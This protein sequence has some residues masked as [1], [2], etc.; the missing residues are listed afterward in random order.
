MLFKPNLLNFSQVSDFPHDVTTN[1]LSFRESFAKIREQNFLAAI[2][3]TAHVK[4]FRSK[5]LTVG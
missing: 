3:N 2:L 1:T 4:I 5:S